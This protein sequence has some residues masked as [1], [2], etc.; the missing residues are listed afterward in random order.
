M[1]IIMEWYNLLTESMKAYP[2]LQA[3]FLTVMS[4]GVM[5]AVGF[6]LVRMPRSVATFFR[7]Q[8]LT[9]LVFNTASSG[10]SDYNQMQYVAFIKWFSKNRW[11]GWSRTITFDSDGRKDGDGVGPGLGRHFFFHNWRLF[12]FAI[13]EMDSQGTNSQKYK[14]SLSCVGRSKKPIYAVMEEFMVKP[15]RENRIGVYRNGTDGWNWVTYANKRSLRSVIMS[16]ELEEQLVGSMTNFINNEAWYRERGLNYK[17]TYLLYGPPGTGKSSLGR[18]LA[19][20]FNRD[21]YILSLSESSDLLTL[22][23][24]AKGGM[25]LIEDIDGFSAARKRSAKKNQLE[26]PKSSV[27]PIQFDGNG[28]QIADSQSPSKN[29]E[30]IMAEWGGMNTSALLNALDGVVGLDDVIILLSTNHPEK[31]DPALIRDGRVDIRVEV[32]FLRSAEI[33]RYINLFFP[34]Y[35]I[36]E[37]M[38]FADMPGCT[39][40]RHFMENKNNPE[41]FVNALLGT[42]AGG[43]VTTSPIRPE[44]AFASPNYKEAVNG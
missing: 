23:Q 12:I 20:H 25:V 9:S 39:V 44:M 17:L 6:A 1:N 3:A 32:G 38:V 2:A 33:R 26:S 8:C 42:T 36:P 15:D 43:S 10:W 27:Q 40:Q 14:V 24:N 41:G 4:G 13:H 19:S 28:E 16:P 21:L 29:L 34:D 37:G 22:L 11:F 18:A 31:L 30:D 7:N 5:A 35:V